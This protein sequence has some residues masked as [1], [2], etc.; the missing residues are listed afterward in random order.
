[1]DPKA[2]KALEQILDKKLE[3]VNNKLDKLSQTIDEHTEKLDSLTLDMS[4]VQK[5]TDAIADIRDMLSGTKTQ[6]NDHEER[7]TTLEAA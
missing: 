5:K 3:P 4:D 1:M 6:V 2:V 7:I